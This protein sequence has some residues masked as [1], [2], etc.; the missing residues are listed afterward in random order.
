MAIVNEE[1]KYLRKSLHKRERRK[2]I[3]IYGVCAARMLKILKLEYQKKKVI[4][5]Y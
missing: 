3:S 2:I 1:S 5:N 4:K